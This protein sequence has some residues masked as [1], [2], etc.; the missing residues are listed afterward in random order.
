ML[1]Y[2]RNHGSWPELVSAFWCHVLVEI[3]ED[4]IKNPL[5][6]PAPQTQNLSLWPQQLF[7][8]SCNWT[9]GMAPTQ[10]YQFRWRV[11]KGNHRTQIGRI[12]CD[13]RICFFSLY[14]CY[15]FWVTNVK[16]M[17]EQPWTALLGYKT[18]PLWALFCVTG[19]ELCWDVRIHCH[20]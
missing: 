4:N 1:S 11:E 7:L 19:T 9:A 20:D 3:L 14:I 5:V 12:C 16:D 10:F 8:C 6:P 18:L 15:F 2:C 17:W 13:L